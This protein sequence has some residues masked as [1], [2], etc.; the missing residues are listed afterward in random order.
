MYPEQI[1][2]RAHPNASIT[3]SL[4]SNTTG[5]VFASAVIPSQP[6]NVVNWTHVEAQIKCNVTA[7]DANNVLAV[8]FD[9]KEASGQTYY[10]NM[11]S[12]FGETFKGV[13]NGLRKDLAESIYD[14]KP[15]FLRWPGG[16]NL[17]GWSIER[18]WKWHETI[19]PLRD[20]VSRPGTWG[21]WNTNGLGLMEF[22]SWA[23]TMEMENVLGIYAGYTLG[24][25]MGNGG[26]EYPTTDAAMYP[27]LKEALDELE[28]CLGSTD[29]KWGAKRAELGHPEPY[30]INYVEIGNEDFLSEDYELRFNYLYPRLKAAYPDITFIYTSYDKADPLQN[31]KNL[32]PG[33]M[34]DVHHYFEPEQFYDSFDVWDNWQEAHN[35]T[36]V[37]VE[38]GEYSVQ[39]ENGSQILY[40]DVTAA[41]GEGVYLLGAE[42]NPNV[43]TMSCYA[44]SLQNN[45]Y[46]SWTPNMILFDAD[47]KHTVLSTSYY[48]QKMFNEFHGTETLPVTNTNGA[49]KPL[50]WAAAI[51]GSE[52]VYLKVM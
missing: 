29:T 16:N 14:L 28:F 49:I 47:P 9:P 2:N 45:N 52:K 25:S 24:N 15:K 17:E 6:W 44:P 13:E 37:T 40:P 18:R 4:Q 3:V 34:W 12:L 23:E 50:Y 35:N 32:P 48:L 39:K 33:T 38:I 30:V 20:R 36:N 8:T 41:L 19:G 31:A 22:L 10:F 43:V 21:Y 46:T 11:I 27:V 26:N 5:D 51:D 7:P 42:R 1:T